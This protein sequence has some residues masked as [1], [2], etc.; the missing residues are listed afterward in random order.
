MQTENLIA[1]R[2][3]CVSHQ[4]KF[5]FIETLQHYGLIEVTTIDRTSFVHDSELP[6]LEQFVRLY[7]ELDINFEG[8]EAITHLLQRMQEMH[9][10]IIMLRNKLSMYETDY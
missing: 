1:L 3:F 7:H 9:N 4:L 8:M 10:E 2:D 6:K 5:S